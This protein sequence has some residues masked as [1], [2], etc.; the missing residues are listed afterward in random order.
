ME[1]L[2]I[3]LLEDDDALRGE[4]SEFFDGLS[5]L[6]YSAAT[7]TKA[8]ELLDTAEID[9]A[10]VDI[11]LPEMNGLE[12][13]K[14]IKDKYPAIESI[15]IT[16]HGDMPTVIEA[17]RAGATDFFNKPLSLFDI[18]DSLQRTRKHTE[19][20]NKQKYI[21]LKYNLVSKKL[22]SQFGL[23]I[24]GSSAIMKNIIN[25]VSKVSETD[26]TTVLITG[27]SGTGKELIARSIHAMS[28][29][30]EKYFQSVNCSAI[31]ETLY[32]SEF[33]GHEK[34]AFT[35]ADSNTTGWFELSNHGT[36]FLD[37]VGELPLNVQAKFLRVLDEKIINKVGA[38][39]GIRIDLRII[40][41]TNQPL[42]DMVEKKSFRVDLYHRLNSFVIHLPPLRERKQDIPDLINYYVDY[43][44]GQM[45]KKIAEVEDKVYTAFSDYYFPGNVRELKNMIEQA[46][47]LC[48]NHILE[49]RHIKNTQK[50][51]VP[52]PDALDDHQSLDLDTIEKRVI[53]RALQK[54]HF[55]KSKT[56]RLLNISRQALD[57]KIQ[58]YGI[59]EE[60]SH[61]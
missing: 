53:T 15:A 22:K 2:K 29:R 6:C 54:C 14:I 33:F 30:S 52:L 18:K 61:R 59:T 13:L 37:E 5:C 31:P 1:Q 10:I 21:D 57:R 12:V 42:E 34:G 26:S 7:P 47:I 39:K 32:E 49:F 20:Q 43:F 23:E 27:E 44:S 58:K 17:F 4:L 60:T 48:E 41:A 24:A 38:K 46:I 25:L 51:P 3:L 9:I 55:N 36:L 19:L 16:G 8:F 35:G 45:G 56:A 40:A 50:R 11:F 28:N